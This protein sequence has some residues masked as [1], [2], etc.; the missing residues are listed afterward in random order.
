MWLNN[1]SVTRFKEVCMDARK[2]PIRA[3]QKWEYRLRIDNQFREKPNVSFAIEAVVPSDDTSCVLKLVV[4]KLDAEGRS[5]WKEEHEFDAHLDFERLPFDRLVDVGSL[6][7][8]GW[9]AHSIMNV[10]VDRNIAF[11][12]EEL[13]DAHFRVTDSDTEPNGEEEPKLIFELKLDQYYMGEVLLPWS[14]A[15]KYFDNTD[16]DSNDR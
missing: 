11:M 15:G 3:N 9:T 12:L 7:R 16:R 10:V 2:E 5:E 13:P 8:F 4:V 14:Y 6:I 1:P